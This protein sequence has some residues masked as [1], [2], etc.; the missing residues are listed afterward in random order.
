MI[1]IDRRADVVGHGAEL[2]ADGLLEWDR[3]GDIEPVTNHTLRTACLAHIFHRV[4]W[5]P[6]VQMCLGR[7]LDTPEGCSK[8]I[9]ATQSSKIRGMLALAIDVDILRAP[10][11]PTIDVVDQAY[12]P[13]LE[14]PIRYSLAWRTSPVSGPISSSTAQPEAPAAIPNARCLRRGAHEPCDFDEFW[15]PLR[16]ERFSSCRSG[17]W[18]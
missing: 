4:V 13:R 3:I 7:V 2:K 11:A 9:L 16:V 15:K 6:I 17:V 18:R 1:P 8:G 10:V 14:K 5:H 12:P